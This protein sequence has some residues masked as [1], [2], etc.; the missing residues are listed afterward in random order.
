MTNNVKSSESVYDCRIRAHYSLGTM[1]M[2][3]IGI[4]LPVNVAR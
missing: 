3:T 4:R 2:A 1:N